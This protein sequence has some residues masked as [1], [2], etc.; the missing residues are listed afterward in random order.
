MNNP[1]PDYPRL[2]KRLREEGVVVL[3]LVVHKDGSV[4][5]VEVQRSSGYPRLDKAALAAVRNWRY[6][7]ATRNGEA[8]DYRYRQ[9]IEFSL[10]RAQQ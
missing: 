7:P 10:T 9:P 4:S 3:E 2:S 5:Q 1:A 8:I 6:V